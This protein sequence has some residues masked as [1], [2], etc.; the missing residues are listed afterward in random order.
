MTIYAF[1]KPQRG[2]F[3][4]IPHCPFCGKKHLHGRGLGSRVPHCVD[5]YDRRRRLVWQRPTNVQYWLT[6]DPTLHGTPVPEAL[7]ADVGMYEGEVQP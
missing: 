7:L 1:A 2:G 5:R 3:W 4:D 6:D